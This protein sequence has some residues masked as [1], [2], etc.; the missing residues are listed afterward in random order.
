MSTPSLTHGDTSSEI[1]LGPRG[2]GAASF[3]QSSPARLDFTGVDSGTL[4]TEN[5]RIDEEVCILVGETLESEIVERPD[6]SEDRGRA[7]R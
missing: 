5:L 2:P 4:K 3:R 1:I 6:V 7:N